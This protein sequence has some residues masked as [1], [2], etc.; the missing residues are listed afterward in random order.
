[1]DLALLPAEADAIEADCYVVVDVLRA[2]TT[3]A[4][5]LAA[6]A[7]SVVAADREALARS[8]AAERGALLFG[9]AG[10]L[11]PPGFDGGNSPLEAREAAV[12]GRD[13]VL[14]TTNG[15]RALTGLAA[16]GTVLAGALA[17]ATTVA[18]A[19]SA[20]ERVCVV[21]AGEARGRRFALE[22]F[23]AAAVILRRILAAASSTE[24]G[25]AAGLA[26]ETA[27]YDD[28]LRSGLP[29]QTVASARLIAGSEHAR[30]LAELGLSADVQFS[31][32][33]DTTQAVPAVTEWGEG[34]ARL[35]AL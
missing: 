1:M 10:G 9:E 2:T 5:L 32:L 16:R 20:F 15:T 22:D 3:I 12:A 31:S 25:D 7:T 28:W 30:A 24:P 4:T 11:P 8:M 29:Q 19:A 6:G 34:W 18:R 14:F 17:N 23:A 27:R 21:C 33:E 35:R 26:I 13:V